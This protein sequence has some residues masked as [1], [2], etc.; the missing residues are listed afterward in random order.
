MCWAIRN[1]SSW[2]VYIDRETL[3]QPPWTLGGLRND[4]LHHLPRRRRYV[5]CWLPVQPAPAVEPVEG[6]CR[7]GVGAAHC[8]QAVGK[9]ERLGVAKPGQQLAA[10]V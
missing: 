5:R 4:Q 3:N 8:T 10:G 7:R 9:P 1:P 2:E 6:G